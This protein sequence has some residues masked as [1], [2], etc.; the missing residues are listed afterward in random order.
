MA[1]TLPTQLSAFPST[2]RPDLAQCQAW[3]THDVVIHDCQTAFDKLPVNEDPIQY[4]PIR[5]DPGD[6]KGLL[7][8]ETHNQ[9]QLRLHASGKWVEENVFAMDISPNKIR[10]MFGRLM[11]KCVQGKRIG[12]FLTNGINNTMK[13]LVREDTEFP[14]EPSRKPGEPRNLHI[15]ESA[16]FLTAMI[17]HTP[18]RGRSME[19][20]PG[21]NH[22][23]ASDLLYRAL[24]R[25]V[26][27]LEDEDPHSTF[28][29]ELQR[30]E[31]F[32][33]EMIGSYQYTQ[34][35]PFWTWWGSIRKPFRPISEN[36]SLTLFNAT[37]LSIPSIPVDAQ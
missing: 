8:V 11:D 22:P 27:D 12:G 30:R 36:G 13:W 37:G 19:F 28:I 32:I 21:A 10:N 4:R 3:F 24:Q 17:W 16:T 26:I 35:P 9:C 5:R 15:P 1:L 29:R 33:S 23:I 20:E 25:A 6:A 31:Q 34:R 2:V 14:G 18:G 7:V